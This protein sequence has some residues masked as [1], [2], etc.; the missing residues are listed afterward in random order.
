MGVVGGHVRLREGRAGGERLLAGGCQTGVERRQG[1]GRER[2][3]WEDLDDRVARMEVR[4]QL[5]VRVLGV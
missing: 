2:R 4:K 3:R 5:F 1:G